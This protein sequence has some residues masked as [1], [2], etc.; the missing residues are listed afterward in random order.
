MTTGMN[1][2]QE[3]RDHSAL[4][5]VAVDWVIKVENGLSAQEQQEFTH[6]LQQDKAHQAMYQQ[7][8]QP[9][10][11][12]DVLAE[13][14]ALF[15]YVKKQKTSKSRSYQYAMASVF[16]FAIAFIASHFSSSDLPSSPSQFAQPSKAIP[17]QEVELKTY[18][19]T[20]GA[21]QS[22][23][24]PDGSVLSLTGGAVVTMQYSTMERNLTLLHGELNIDVV[25]DT[26]RPLSVFAGE[27]KIQA[28]GTSFNVYLNERQVE[29]I[30]AEGKVKVSQ[31]DIETAESEAALSQE[32]MES[33]QPAEQVQFVTGGYQL[34]LPKD[35]AV[36]SVEPSQV[37]AQQI[38]TLT[39][40]QRGL[41]T[42]DQV[43]ISQAIAAIQ[44]YSG[45][46]FVVPDALLQR[47]P[48]IVARFDLSDISSMVQ[49]LEN[50][51]ALHSEWQTP[52]QILLVSSET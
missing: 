15:P 38:E 49:I 25:P 26:E 8:N 39:A 35:V 12:A 3:Q 42:F 46:T 7:V 50:T 10:Q 23:T 6:W 44:R 13:L 45:I 18:V 11:E 19:A 20:T 9:I 33:E 22:Y 40:W 36:T 27:R 17:A 37:E 34:I 51:F 5:D 24:L 41:V 28:V 14:G 32:N 52:S 21:P 30:V 48:E 29:L 47:D 2:K 43:P 4:L 1:D 16:A 31:D